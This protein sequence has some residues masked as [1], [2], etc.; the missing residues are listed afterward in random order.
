M[1]NLKLHNTNLAISGY[2]GDE[3][4]I[5]ML[6]YISH[7][8]GTTLD[9]DGAKRPYESARNAETKVN[10]TKYIGNKNSGRVMK[11]SKMTQVK[12]PYLSSLSD[13]YNS[14]SIQ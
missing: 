8:S 12:L 10:D 1:T 7:Y 6:T 3:Y 11:T 13:R 2:S 9:G 4:T 14:K 5:Y